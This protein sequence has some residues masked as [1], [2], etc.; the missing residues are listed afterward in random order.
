MVQA[1]DVEVHEGA[2]SNQTLNR[3]LGGKKAKGLPFQ[4][5]FTHAILQ[6]APTSSEGNNN[7]S[8]EKLKIN[9]HSH[10]LNFI[11]ANIVLEKNPK[12]EWKINFNLKY[13]H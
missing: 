6:P 4:R 5:D 2:R 1:A 10:C 3:C 9:K 13:M 8:C 7:Q 11:S 12:P